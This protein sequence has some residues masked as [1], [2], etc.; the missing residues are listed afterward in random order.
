V[1]K[2]PAYHH[3]KCAAR[4]LIIEAQQAR[5][6]PAFSSA[7]LQYGHD[8][9]QDLGGDPLSEVLPAS[10]VRDLGATRS[11]AATNRDI[12]AASGVRGA[13][14]VTVAGSIQTGTLK[15]AEGEVRSA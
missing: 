5:D 8:Y 12:L 1:R 4:L 3:T 7:R 9:T 15:V 14:C 10:A 2:L 13:R 11:R 6:R